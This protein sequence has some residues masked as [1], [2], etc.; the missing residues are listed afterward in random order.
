MDITSP[1]NDIQGAKDTGGVPL[2]IDPS[3]PQ[4]MM[5]A[6]SSSL[7]QKSPADATGLPTEDPGMVIRMLLQLLQTQSSTPPPP[8]P[9]PA[10]MQPPMGGMPPSGGMM[11][12]GAPP[13]GPPMAGMAPQGP[14][15]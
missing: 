5:Q 15:Q 10:P 8:P 2:A 6:M 3:D 11:G 12:A 9:P 1:D 7:M 4:G 14:P 13:P